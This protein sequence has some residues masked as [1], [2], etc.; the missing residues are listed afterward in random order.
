MS[1]DDAI[2]LGAWVK[3]AS[4]GF[5][6]VILGVV[7]EGV[8]H[9]RRFPKEQ[10]TRKLKI[11]K[12]GW[13]ILVVGLA[14][15]FLGDQFAKRI[16]DR[17]TARLAVLAG[18]ANRTAEEL[19]ATNLVMQLK[20]Q[21]RRITPSQVT[22][23]VFLTEHV[24]KIPIKVTMGASEG[25]TGNFAGQLRAALISAGFGIDSSAGALG[26]TS[27]SSRFLYSKIG[28]DFPLPS[29]LLVCYSTNGQTSL[30]SVTYSTG[31]QGTRLIVT[32]SNPTEI[33]RAIFVALNR[34]GIPT[35]VTGNT[36]WVKPCQR[37]RE[38]GGKEAV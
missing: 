15:E 23:F 27:E 24:T 36:T 21:P 30:S 31:P 1:T 29:V 35:D 33:Y 28:T 6:L 18:N 22:N 12:A 38:S 32:N 8:G 14:M 2:W 20:L 19:R 7:L 13:L 26:V 11:E 34:V 37:R 4:F 25:D 10:D 9:F 17:E 3:L 16:A 5:L